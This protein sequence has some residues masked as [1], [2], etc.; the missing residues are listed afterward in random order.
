MPKDRF[1]L[2]SQFFPC[3]LAIPPSHGTMSP[4]IRKSLWRDKTFE[5][6]KWVLRLS[7]DFVVLAGSESA[8][9]VGGKFK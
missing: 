9:I 3:S 2:P 5:S 1:F 7:D 8:K 6:S 4:T